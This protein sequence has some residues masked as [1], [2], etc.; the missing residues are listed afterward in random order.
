MQKIEKLGLTTKQPPPCN[1][2]TNC[3]LDWWPSD[4]EES[5]RRLMAEPSWKAYIE[6]QGWDKPGAITYKFN[7]MGYRGDDPDWSKPL[8][9]T[10]GCSLTMG[11]GLPQNLTWPWLVGQ[12]LGLEVVNFSMGGMPADWCFRMAEF[13]VPIRR[14]VLAVMLAPP[15]ERIEIITDDQRT[16]RT[17]SAHETVH[18]EFLQTWFTYNEN[19][20]LNNLRNKLAF[21]ALCEHVGVPGLCYDAYEWFAKSREEIGFARDWMHGGPP[22]H[23]LLADK[24]INDWNEIKHT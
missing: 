10:F 15:H 5:F 11:I 1:F 3:E 6:Q 12:E 21:L 22:G 17:Y 14:P 8:L 23:R 16:G 19:V 2:V 9:M 4:S 18:G 13:W 20:R 7:S 24:V